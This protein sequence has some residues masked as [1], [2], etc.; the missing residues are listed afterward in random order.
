MYIRL[1]SFCCGVNIGIKNCEISLVAYL[2]WKSYLLESKNT[3]V[4]NNKTI[5]FFFWWNQWKFL[6]GQGKIWTTSSSEK[7]KC[8]IGLMTRSLAESDWH[9]SLSDV[10]FW[11]ERE[12]SLL[13]LYL[14]DLKEC[15]YWMVVHMIMSSY[16]PTKPLSAPLDLYQSIH[17]KDSSPPSAISHHIP[18]TLDFPCLIFMLIFFLT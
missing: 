9:D 7:K 4:K 18:R 8:Y 15:I 16:T 11:N 6:A 3:W 12:L 14:W 1:V 17:H 10:M 2:K 5:T 13:L